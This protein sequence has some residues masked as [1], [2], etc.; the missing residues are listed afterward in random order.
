[1]NSRAIS[2]LLVFLQRKDVQ[3]AMSIAA[4]ALVVTLTYWGFRSPYA[5]YLQPLHLA[6][7]SGVFALDPIIAN[8]PLLNAGIYYSLVKLLN[9]PIENDLIGLTLHF[10]LNGGVLFLLFR[11]ARRTFGLA[12]PTHAALFVLVACFFYSK[13][14]IGA[15]AQ[16]IAFH[17]PTPTGLAHVTGI[18]ALLFAIDRRFALAAMLVTLCVALAPKGNILIVPAFVLFVL[19]DR[20]VPK[21]VYAYAMLP[22]AYI[23]YRALDPIVIG[24]SHENAVQLTYAIMANE[25]SDGLFSYQPVLANI[26]LATSFALFPFLVRAFTNRSLKIMAWSLYVV[27]L[28]AVAVNAVYPLVYEEFPL[29]ILVMLAFPQATKYFLFVFSAMVIARI[30][31]EPR[32]LWHEKLTALIAF[33]A[34]K[35]FPTQ[36]SLVLAMVLAGIAAP[37][38]Y[39]LLSGKGSALEGI[40]RRC[41]AIPLPVAMAVFLSG[42][43]LLRSGTTYASPSW[44]DLVAFRHSGTWSAS[45]WADDETWRTWEALGRMQG[46]F[47]LLAVYKRYRVPS[48][49]L[50]YKRQ[51]ISHPV[52][53]TISGKSQFAN[54][55]FHAYM[56]LQ[57]YYEAQHPWEVRERIITRLNNGLPIDNTWVGTFYIRNNDKPFSIN[58][59]LIGFLKKRG[60]R[61][62]VPRELE[63]L[64]P[65]DAH[66][67]NVGAQVLISFDR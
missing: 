40:A 26:L 17:T 19:V 8:S 28:G 6:R 42:F 55:P 64:F 48:P 36:V 32:L 20:T 57:N 52:I 21:R 33:V 4:I 45:V 38:V 14:V 9:F 35:P 24:A 16:P 12:D 67:E 27:T 59:T 56:N 63:N 30:L 50:G 13:F 44:I 5:E 62:L 31:N 46:D 43:V 60:V 37:R 34:L 39:A 11:Q 23:A 22:I 47:P 18:A 25:E 66:H 58:D 2:D 29:P 54:V 51:Y 49:H 15:M 3:V 10:F 65:V 1:M 61:V 7:N 41:A 53:S